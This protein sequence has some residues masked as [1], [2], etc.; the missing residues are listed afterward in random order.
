MTL[1]CVCFFF[2]FSIFH[3]LIFHFSS[4]LLTIFSATALEAS[5]VYSPFHICRACYHFSC[6][7]GGDGSQSDSW[8]PHLLVVV[9]FQRSWFS[10]FSYIPHKTVHGGYLF[11]DLFSFPTSLLTC[12]KHRKNIKVHGCI[13]KIIKK[14]IS[15]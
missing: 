14:Y 8:S 12:F 7:D 15:Y 10:Q 4:F 2:H 5:E 6:Y 3:F 11:F 1:T 9:F 13:N